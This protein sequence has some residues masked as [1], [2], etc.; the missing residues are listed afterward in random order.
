MALHPVASLT[1]AQL[2]RLAVAAGA[3][4]S[5]AMVSVVMLFLGACGLT[6]SIAASDRLSFA[7]L[8]TYGFACVAVIIAAAI[9]GFIVPAIIKHMVGDGPEAAHQWQ[10][11][12]TAIFQ[13]NQSFV[14]IYSVGASLAVILWSLS[15]LRNGGLSRGVAIYGC[16]TSV[17]IILGVGSGHWRFDVHGMAVLWLSQS[18]WFILVG[19]RL[20][21]A[22]SSESYSGSA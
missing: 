13:I 15:G 4:H 3:V 11:I 5:L 2:A 19:S 14:G 22:Q 1:P 17:L 12:V 7:A 9:S 18:I 6:R 20:H 16:I 10:M 21:S 8:V